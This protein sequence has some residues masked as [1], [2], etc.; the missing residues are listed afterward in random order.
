[1]LQAGS[2]KGISIFKNPRNI[3]VILEGLAINCVSQYIKPFPILYKAVQFNSST[4]VQ[5][6]N[7]HMEDSLLT[8]VSFCN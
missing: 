3:H 8:G 6:P 1:M 5:S 4:N 7:D 2:E